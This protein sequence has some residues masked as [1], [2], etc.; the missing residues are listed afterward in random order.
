MIPVAPDGA[1]IGE[2][3]ENCCFCYRH[4]NHWHLQ[5]DVAVCEECAETHDVRDIPTKTAWCEAVDKK[6]PTLTGRRWL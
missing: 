5:K 4:T 1:P 3:R 2:P 6:F